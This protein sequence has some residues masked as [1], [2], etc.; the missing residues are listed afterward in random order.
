MQYYPVFLDL[1]GRDCLVV[2]GGIVACRKAAALQKA[3]AR[4]HVV[5]PE[6]TG[7][8]QGIAVA[9]AGSYHLRPFE[10]PDLD[11]KMLVIAAT[12]QRKVNE[13]IFRGATERNILANVV[14]NAD[15]CNFITASIVDRSPLL[16][17][18]SSSGVAPVLARLVRSRI[19]TIFP[20]TFG[21]L[22]AFMGKYRRRV[23]SSFPREPERRRFWESILAGPVAEKVLAGADEE[24]GAMLEARLATPE[25]PFAG[26]VCLVGAG[27]GDPD[28]LT[29][30]AQRLLQSADIIFYDRLVNPV[31]VGLAR[32]DAEKVYVGKEQSNHPVPQEEI[33]ELLI[34]HA[35]QG[36]RVVRLKGGDP[37]IFGRGAEEIEGLAA[38]GIPFQVVPGI[39]AASGCASYSGIPLTH[40]D[41]AQS[42]RFVTGHLKNDSCNLN[43]AELVDAD[44][45]VVFYM[46]LHTLEPICRGLLEHGRSPSTPIA[47][48]EKGTLPGQRVHV[49]T[50]ATVPDLV[51]DRGIQSPA[52]II[53]GEVVA[54]H[55]QLAWFFTGRDGRD[56]D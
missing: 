3:G 28:L 26:E 38:L 44:Q 4:I 46:G 56:V 41:Y 18:V 30:K 31:I 50:L 33:N 37:F 25:A 14:D 8:L 48:V 12:S 9:T 34:R 17:A 53:V 21:R 29:F 19:E 32:N 24:A 47:L 15:I 11:H 6:I 1:R 45:T 42:V 55:Q 49:G 2:G 52:L 54:L 40:R 43:W 16:I 51:R 7:E 35:K 20:S 5:A 13:E 22:A 36:K 10:L 39:T 27:P 23:K